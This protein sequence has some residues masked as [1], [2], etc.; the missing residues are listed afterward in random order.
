MKKIWFLWYV[1][2]CVADVFVIWRNCF[3]PK[4]NTNLLAASYHIRLKLSNSIKSIWR[5]NFVCLKESGM[6]SIQMFQEDRELV[7]FPFSIPNLI[8]L[9]YFSSK[10]KAV[11]AWLLGPNPMLNSFKN[12][13]IVIKAYQFSVGSLTVFVTHTKADLLT[14]ML[15]E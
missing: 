12:L 8:L 14:L 9:S 10:C 13:M 4:A 2:E 5:D 1:T 3:P 6:T 7:G 15:M 11:T